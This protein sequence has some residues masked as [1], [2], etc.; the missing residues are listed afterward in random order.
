MNPPIV[1]PVKPPENDIDVNE[2][3]HENLPKQPTVITIYGAFK[4]GKSVLLANMIENDDFFRGRMDKVVLI[5]PTALN[6][7]T[8]RHIVEDDDVEIISDYSD[9]YLQ[10]LLDFQMETP[11]EDRSRIMLI[12]DDALQYIKPRGKGSTASHLATKFRHYNIGYLVYVSQY[13]KALPP[14]IRGNTGCIVVMKI[15]NIK[16]L[17]D[18]ADELDGFLNNNFMKLYAYCI[19]DQPYSFMSINMRDYNPP[20]VFNRFE[21]PIYQG[22]WLI[23]EPENVDLSNL[24]RSNEDLITEQKTK[25]PLLEKKTKKDNLR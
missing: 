3:L 22:S 1:L 12:F 20:M 10:A 16:T 8:Y 15:P 24:L 4:A 14:M 5:S 11:K 19:Y 13:Y 9:E 6:D 17:K 21:T 2:N 18:M 7:D 25:K 23:D